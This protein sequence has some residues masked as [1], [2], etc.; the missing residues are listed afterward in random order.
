MRRMLIATTG[1]L[2]LSASLLVH[3]EQQAM[4]DASDQLQH[5]SVSLADDSS[6][7]DVRVATMTRSTAGSVSQTDRAI[8]PVD[9]V[10]DLPVRVRTMWWHDQKAG[11]KLADL[12]GQSGRFVIQWSVEN[13]TA[14]PTD[15]SYESNGARYKQSE[16]VAVPLTVAASA[17]LP[18]GEAVVGDSEGGR[19]TNGV[20]APLG[21]GRTTV[22]WAAL[23]APPELSPTTLFTLVV[24]AE[25]FETPELMLSVQSGVTTDPSMGA[26]V[27]AAFG[28]D[29]AARTTEQEIVQTVSDVTK[30][31]TEARDFVD[32]VHETLQSDVSTIAGRTFS[33]LQTS[34]RRVSS[35]LAAT[36]EQLA[37]ISTSTESAISS[38]SSGTRQSLNSL[39]AS[40]TSL[41]GTNGDPKTT[42]GVVEG[43]SISLPQLADDEKRTVSATFALV[44]KQMEVV[45][46]L[47][48]N[49]DENNNCRDALVAA[50]S[51]A[52]GDPD[53]F[54]DESA[55]R[56]CE[57]EGSADASLSCAI[58]RLDH[59]LDA[60]IKDIEDLSSKARRYYRSLG[61]TELMSSLQGEQGLA[62]QLSQLSENVKK[63]QSDN[64]V[65]AMAAH[66]QLESLRR[67]VE[68]AITSVKTAQER[69]GAVRGA[70]DKVSS[71]HSDLLED[72]VSSNPAKPGL[73]E[74]LD[75]IVTDGG[76]IKSTGAWFVGSG[77]PEALDTVIA[78]L[79]AGGAHA[80]RSDWRASLSEGSSAAQIS[81]AL[82]SLS[83]ENCPLAG[84]ADS[85]IAMVTTY[86]E[87]VQNASALRHEVETVQRAADDIR[88]DMQALNDT[89]T[90]TRNLIAEDAGLVDLMYGLYDDR[91]T[92][93][94]P[95]PT[96][97]LAEVRNT[98][99]SDEGIGSLDQGKTINDLVKLVDSMWPDS[100]VQPMTGPD[101]CANIDAA[102]AHP[103]P[104]G[105][106]VVWLTNRL[107]CL[108]DN[109]GT[110]LDSLDG[111]IKKV[112]SAIDDELSSAEKRAELTLTEMTSSVD[113]LGRQLSDVMSEQRRLTEAD[114]KRMIDESQAQRDSELTLALNSLSMSTTSTIDGLKTAL[115]RSSEQSVVVSEQLSAQFSTLLINLGQPDSS[116]RLGLIGKLHGITTDVGETGNVLNGVDGTVTSFATSRKGALRRINL[117][118]AVYEHAQML[119]DDYRPFTDSNGRLV[120]V[121]TY[122]MGGH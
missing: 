92:P 20:V 119:E 104:S 7:S 24:D 19:V 23:L 71:A 121:F 43:C 68:R 74:R 10:R 116:S 12:Q 4:A 35:Q 31:L 75:G 26:L 94:H 81:S 87:T 2:A 17:R 57:S 58:H 86:E 118:S 70:F 48:E 6:V 105:Q 52:V 113:G 56:E 80:C 44:N 39:V 53:A 102:N 114:V 72:L 79:N 99:T 109:L 90:E 30:S 1:V 5:V 55:A 29:G 15:V 110:A 46:S 18:S 115:S 108:D 73:L 65:L 60:R 96:G 22:Q 97:S 91:I 32:E 40:F 100:S 95:K 103:A 61:T 47:F 27:T 42:E 8:A 11:T 83:S 107:V 3:A 66:D 78:Q 14:K 33:D 88:V 37:S 69:L 16:L 84:L 77:M 63:L 34:S 62:A 50:L 13:L 36:N 28:V 51:K 45:G 64:G 122:S 101:A 38:A 25:S 59:R 67:N 85:A 21:E 106:A 98:I 111:G 41:L 89:I 9:A 93:D 76:Q 117:H 82:S 49:S 112:D 54:K 120:T